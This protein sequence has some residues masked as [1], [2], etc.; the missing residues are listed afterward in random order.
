MTTEAPKPPSRFGRIAGAILTGMVGF[1]V[2]AGIGFGI[3]SALIPQ[4]VAAGADPFLD[5]TFGYSFFLL[6]CPAALVF[7]SLLGWLGTRIGKRNTSDRGCM[8]LILSGLVS[9]AGGLMLSLAWYVLV[10]YTG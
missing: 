9:L 8:G 2:G 10:A 3:A 4:A 6:L 7:G 1:A 5:E